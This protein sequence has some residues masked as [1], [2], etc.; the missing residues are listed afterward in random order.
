MDS[1][2]IVITAT[3]RRTNETRL[4]IPVKRLVQI[5]AVLVIAVLAVPPALA[6]Q[7][8]CSVSTAGH[9]C[10][11][12]FPIGAHHAMT[13]TTLG[14]TARRP[15]CPVQMIC[16]IHQDSRQQSAAAA[17]NDAAGV[18]PFIVTQAVTQPSRPMPDL[19]RAAP[20]HSARYMLFRVFRI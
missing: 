18:A 7:V 13:G 19:A 6:A 11:H 10:C 12:D 17:A 1:T 3:V 16:G 2:V 20:A 5:V 4:Q 14:S 8:A 9:A 15:C